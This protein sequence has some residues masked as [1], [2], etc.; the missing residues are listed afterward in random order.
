MMQN[1]FP[2]IAINQIAD[3]LSEAGRPSAEEVQFHVVSCAWSNSNSRM[4]RNSEQPMNSF[5]KSR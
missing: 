2:R 4:R 3:P 5:E 1:G